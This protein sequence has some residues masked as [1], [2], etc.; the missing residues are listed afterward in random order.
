MGPEK[1]YY[2]IFGSIVLGLVIEFESDGWK[3]P[4]V[5]WNV[6]KYNARLATMKTGIYL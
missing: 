5:G 6:R 1:I 3:R 4:L 2:L